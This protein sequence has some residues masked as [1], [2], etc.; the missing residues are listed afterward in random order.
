MGLAW[1]INS[2]GSVPN[3]TGPGSAPVTRTVQAKVPVII[4]PA[5]DVPPGVL[6]WLYS[7]TSATALQSVE[8]RSPFYTRGNLSLGNGVEVYAPLYVTCVAP[9]GR[10]A[11]AGYAAEPVPATC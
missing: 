1:I 4:G 5:R 2:T 10:A 8:I 11:H 7:V 3:P 9:P 6:N